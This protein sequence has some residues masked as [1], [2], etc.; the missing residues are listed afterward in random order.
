MLTTD[1]AAPRTRGYQNAV[2][3]LIALMVGV[4]LVERQLTPGPLSGPASASA[5]GPGDPDQ[6]GLTNALEQRKIIIAELRTLNAKMERLES[7]LASGLSVKVTDMP[8]LKLPPEAKAKPEA[9]K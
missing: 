5:Q 4:G 6:G 8:P 2:L 1:H 7:K 9:G 3:T